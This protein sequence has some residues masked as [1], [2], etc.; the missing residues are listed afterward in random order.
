M[1]VDKLGLVYIHSST[2]L[3]KKMLK[4]IAILC[5]S[6]VVPKHIGTPLPRDIRKFQ[7]ALRGKEVTGTLE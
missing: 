5:I 4:Y 6:T 7:G 2:N 3:K 1:Q